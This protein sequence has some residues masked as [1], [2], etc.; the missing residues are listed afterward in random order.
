V[1]RDSIELGD[2]ACEVVSG[3]EVAKVLAQVINAAAMVSFNLAPLIVRFRC[4]AAVCVQ[5][6]RGVRSTSPLVY[7]WFGFVS[8]SLIPSASQI[9][10]TRICREYALFG[11]RGRSANWMPPSIA[12]QAIAANC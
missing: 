4:P 1:E 2:P 9:M 10:S 11:L 7:G 8:R 3:H 5:T 6:V 12:R